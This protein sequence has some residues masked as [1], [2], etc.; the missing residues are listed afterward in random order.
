LKSDTLRMVIGFALIVVI[1]IGWQVLFR[2]KPRQQAVPVATQPASAP[3]ATPTPAPEA[4]TTPAVPALVALDATP[5]PE[6]T[7]TLENSLLHVEFSNIGGRLTSARLVKFAA[8]LVPESGTLLGTVLLTDSG[9][10]SLDAAPMTA[11][12]TDS[13]VAFTYAT[14]GLSVTKSFTL[15]PRYALRHSIAVAGPVTGIVLDGSA[16]IALT[17]KSSKEALG[18]FSFSARTGKKTRAVAAAKLGKPFCLTEPASWVAARSK[19]FVMVLAGPDSAFDSCHAARFE[20]GRLG[21]AVAARHPL[22][23]YDYTLYLG[24][25]DDA[26]LKPLGLGAVASHGWTRPIEIAMMW[27]LRLLHSLV[28][29]WGWAIVIF[30]ILMK[31]ALWPLSRT[32]TKQMRQ[33]QLLQPKLNE[34]K[35]KFKDDAQKLNAETM[36]LYKLYKIN[37]LS[38]CLPMVVQLPIFW[39]LYAVLRNAI[40]MRGAHFLLWLRD[41]SQPDTLFGYLPTG[42]PFVGG[43]AVGL[44]PVLMGVSFIAQN[45]ITSTDKKNWALTIL[46]PIFITAIFLNLPSGLQ[47]YWFMY[48]ILSIGETLFA[49]KG[50]KLWRTKTNP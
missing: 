21:F 22:P 33:M 38:G 35:V 28:R 4:K 24:P 10:R 31:A 27:L 2:P 11:T 43:Y 46:F 42:I 26:E 13:S 47:L 40:E 20:D 7:V 5:V 14:G 45:M 37:P 1:L 6:T 30:S 18:Y 44:L 25:V 8:E 17:E 34:L 39:A 23:V 50:G 9:P 3:V 32:Q 15:G 29:N 41:L 19:Y 12:A 16:G 48:N 49:V 36:Q